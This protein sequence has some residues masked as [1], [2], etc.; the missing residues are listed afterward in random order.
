MLGG[1]FQSRARAMSLYLSSVGGVED[2]AEDSKTRWGVA[3]I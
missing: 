2:T 1:R 3:L